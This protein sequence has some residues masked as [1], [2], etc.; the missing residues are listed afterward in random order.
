[1]K[2][3]R[4]KMRT[5]LGTAVALATPLALASSASAMRA[6]DAGTPSPARRVPVAGDPSGLNWAQAAIIVA[7]VLVLTLV[8]L[9]LVRSARNRSSSRHFALGHDGTR[10]DLEGGRQLAALSRTSQSGACS[11]ASSAHSRFAT[12]TRS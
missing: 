9:A 6:V 8:A 11:S 2:R 12:A 1:M 10:G 4:L 5:W 3:H 7:A